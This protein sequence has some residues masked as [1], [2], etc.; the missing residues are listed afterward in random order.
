MKT[1]AFLCHKMYQVNEQ[2]TTA[3]AADL[4]LSDGS[5]SVFQKWMVWKLDTG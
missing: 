1:K 4:L 5:N 3:A 2:Q